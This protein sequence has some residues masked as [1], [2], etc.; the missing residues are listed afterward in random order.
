MHRIWGKMPSI[1][2]SPACIWRGRLR[3]PPG[4]RALTTWP[5]FPSR[6]AGR[7]LGH[8][9]SASPGA[10][11]VGR[12]SDGPVQRKDN[13]R[14]SESIQVKWRHG[15]HESA[16]PNYPRSGGSPVA[17]TFRSTS[18]ADSYPTY[19]CPKNS[20]E[21]A[22]L[23]S[24]RAVAVPCDGPPWNRI[25]FSKPCGAFDKARKLGGVPTSRL[26]HVPAQNL[27][28]ADVDGNNRLT[29]CP[30]RS[31]FR[32]MG[33]VDAVPDADGYEVK[34]Y[35]PLRELPHALNPK[36]SGLLDR[37]PGADTPGRSFFRSRDFNFFFFNSF[38]LLF[39]P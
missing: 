24:A 7:G 22:G 11:N 1:C 18:T 16:Q 4:R 32:P 33:T 2:S 3:G 38:F 10:T 37:H 14:Q 25:I 34:G 21:R 19:T 8:T 36:S 27:I 5:V 29:R 20:A 6:G 26:L 15:G 12:R 35:I 9:R 17:L 39:G 28:Y 13:P 30:A 31:H 23:K